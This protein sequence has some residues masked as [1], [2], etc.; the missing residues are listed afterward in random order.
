M[1]I[2]IDDN[3]ATNVIGIG[4]SAGGL[5]ALK[6]L[7][8]ALEPDGKTAYIVAQHLSPSHA[9]MMVPL[10]SKGT[11][12]EVTEAIEH[13]ALH[14]DTVYI[15]PP[16]TNIVYQNGQVILTTPIDSIAAKPSIDFLFRSLAQS[17]GERS[18]AVVL[19]GTGSDGTAG[20]SEIKSQGG[21]ALVQSPESAEYDGM[22]RS[23]IS[24][25]CADFVN[26]PERLA[27][28]IG[29][30]LKQSQTV[31]LSDPPLPNDDIERVLT[32]IEKRHEL[33]LRGYKRSTQGRRIK[34]R[35]LLTNI[36]TVNQYLELLED[37]AREIEELLKDIFISVTAFFRDKE[38][39][40]SLQKVVRDYILD[41]DTAEFRTWVAGCSTGEEAFTIAIILFEVYGELKIP[42]SFKV[43]ATDISQIAIDT[44]RAGSYSEEALKSLPQ[45]YL[46]KYFT[47]RS[48]DYV[49]KPFLRDAVVFSVHNLVKDPPFSNINLLSC[50]NVI[51]YFDSDLQE[52]VLNNFAY[53]LKSGGLLFLGASESPGSNTYFDVIKEPHRLYRKRFIDVQLRWSYGAGNSKAV[54]TSF[55]GAQSTRSKSNTIDMV[56]MRELANLYG[57]PSLLLDN[58]NKVIFIHGEAQKFL[59]LGSGVFTSNLFDMVL[60][61]LEPTLRALIYRCRKEGA[62][63]R[64]SILVS[65]Q[66][67]STHFRI[68]AN[69][70]TNQHGNWLLL[71]FL[72][73]IENHSEVGSK[74]EKTSVVD[75]DSIVITE[76]EDE[77]N[78]TRM[79]LQVV[80]EQLQTAN[81]ELQS[82]NEELQSANEELQATNEELQTANEELQSSNEELRTLNEEVVLKNSELELLSL[83]LT[84]IEDSLEIP[85]IILDN[86]S[87]IRRFS[88]AISQVIYDDNIKI[89]DHLRAIKFK[90]ELPAELI[91]KI[92][93]I[94]SIQ[95]K[96]KHR[97]EFDGSVYELKALP[98]FS[99]KGDY[100]G[101][102]ISFYDISVFFESQ[103]HLLSELDR[104]HEIFSSMGD[105]IIRCDLNGTIE[106]AN[107]SASLLLG[108]IKEQLRGMNI[109]TACNLYKDVSLS[110]QLPMLCEL[111]QYASRDPKFPFVGYLKS[112][113]ESSPIKVDFTII[114]I[115][116]ISN[117]EVA[118]SVVLRDLS[119]NDQLISKLNQQKEVLLAQRNELRES[120]KK[121]KAIVD[122]SFDALVGI[123]KY[124]TILLVNPAVERM[125]GYQ[126][127]EIIGKNVKMFIPE[128]YQKEH[129][130]Q[131]NKY[132][133]DGIQGLTGQSTELVAIDRQN[134]EFPILLR[135]GKFQTGVKL[136]QG[137]VKYLGCIQDI[138]ETKLQE[139][140]LRRS[141]KLEAVGNL[142]GGVAHDFNNIIGI[143]SGNLELVE[144]ETTLSEDA[145]E[146]L[147]SAMK[148]SKRAKNLTQKLLRFS[149]KVP[150]SQV[151]LDC[152]ESLNDTRLLLERTLPPDIELS[153]S[154][155]ANKTIIL[156]DEG[157]LED[158]ILNLVINARDSISGKG[159]IRINTR[160]ITNGGS[161][162]KS[163]QQDILEEK[164][165]LVITVQDNGRGISK[166]NIDKIFDP[167]F[168]TK[169][170]DNGTGLGLS[171]VYGFCQRSNGFVDIDTLEG[172]GTSVRI[173]L[174]IQDNDTD[175]IKP[176]RKTNKKALPLASNGEKIIV[177][178]DER[179]LLE[180]FRKHLG[181][182]GY[183]VKT[184]S[185]PE[186]ALQYLKSAPENTDLLITDI[187]MPG[188][189]NG[190][191]L[192]KQARLINSALPCLVVSGFIGDVAIPSDVTLI[193]KPFDQY[194]IASAV[195]DALQTAESKDL[196]NG[197]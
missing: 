8:C 86:D 76:L 95:T 153:F 5:K 141:Q 152:H 172:V 83:D 97:Y 163:A 58:A 154:L 79:D 195:F 176:A 186:K 175:Q 100:I 130:G 107:S 64:Q 139:E 62:E 114:P 44:A 170:K 15:T 188:E 197:D 87:R 32:L 67:H 45:E 52:V 105:A 179:D 56:A 2:E 112:T 93:N 171:M 103:R 92:E 38:A 47:Q 57:P 106:F 89:G 73:E 19:S 129:N 120:E 174:P 59:G 24:A 151:R 115:S 85:L 40:K 181:F 70:F 110:T 75:G 113:Q 162:L 88:P 183:Q 193:N 61:E 185:D 98:Y 167:F 63:H 140:K 126:T 164:D 30:L 125:F 124:G 138:S 128:N 137:T 134:K 21:F 36:E 3:A 91:S 66:Q 41:T 78:T 14:S 82:S 194:T 96:Y 116:N 143:I 158:A 74:A 132:L 6:E 42:N 104:L 18:I 109:C 196:H 7:I 133:K 60:P 84:T 35:M 184:F 147:A 146:S 148:A 51:I 191:E 155:E 80:T 65:H 55:K 165:Y 17:F 145:K 101:C 20:L 28:E 71:S 12:L 156:V 31:Y 94:N 131:L 117:Q 37:S 118:Y 29:S 10:I 127:E 177:V 111:K 168:S 144:L 159:Q 192:V 25:G 122:Q 34:R 49:V 69:T 77:L 90:S 1:R 68:E 142:V 99:A 166:K 13:L 150:R 4:A 48:D 102:I 169:D 119:E 182:L 187:V 53:T 136:D 27:K 22:P 173:L 39:Y 43:F 50:R 46:E 157:D 190:I 26:T 11:T 9:S 33:N 160:C 121:L 161:I 178:D 72:S 23:A 108:L 16:N 123:D 135:V 149:R 54:T 81:E 180:V 189:I